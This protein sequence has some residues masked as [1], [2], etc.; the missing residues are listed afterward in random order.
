MLF[1]LLNIAEQKGAAREQRLHFA[2]D[3]HPLGIACTARLGLGFVVQSV[4]NFLS[5]VDQLVGLILGSAGQS[6][7]FS[8]GLGNS[9]VGGALRQQQCA[10]DGVGVGGGRDR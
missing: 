2:L 1:E 4:D 10:A 9:R 6:S 5:A 8:S 7:G 3:L